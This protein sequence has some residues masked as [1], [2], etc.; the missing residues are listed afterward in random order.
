MA[1]H[2]VREADLLSAYDVDRC[3]IYSMVREHLD[4]EWAVR[5]TLKIFDERVFKYRSDGLFVTPYSRNLS[6]RLHE[7]AARD[8]RQL[9]LLL[10]PLPYTDE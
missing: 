6:L 4:Y 5:R 1:Y 9:K 3:I 2:I 8:L 7:K 10:S